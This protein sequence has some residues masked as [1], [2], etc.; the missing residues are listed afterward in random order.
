M[1]KTNIVLYTSQV[2]EKFRQFCM[3]EKNYRSAT[4]HI[5]VD[6]SHNLFIYTILFIHIYIY[7][8][9]YTVSYNI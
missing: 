1:E 6:V 9:I 3:Y 2:F 8:Y 7:I 5:F 4:P